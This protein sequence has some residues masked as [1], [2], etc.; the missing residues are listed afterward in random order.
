MI[1]STTVRYAA[2]HVL[3]SRPLDDEDDSRRWLMI[4]VD[5]AGRR[6]ALVALV[7]DDEFHL[8]LVREAAA[9]RR[10]L[11]GRDVSRKKIERLIVRE[12]LQAR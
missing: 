4:A 6:L 1:I 11:H 8:G 3:S 9:A 7:Y 5:P 10:D 2:S 12:R